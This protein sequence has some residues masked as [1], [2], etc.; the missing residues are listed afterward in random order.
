MQEVLGVLWVAIPAAVLI[1]AAVQDVSTREVSDTHW[2]VMGVACLLFFAASCIQEYGAVPVLCHLAVSVVLLSYMLSERLS[3]W[4]A[5][6]M[7][8][9]VVILSVVT[10]IMTD[11]MLSHASVVSLVV[12]FLFAGM[13]RVGLLRGGADAKCLMTVAVTYPVIPEVGPLPLIWDV[14]Y[15]E[16]LVFGTSV[17]VLVTSL[18]LSLASCAVLTV[19]NLREGRICSKMFTT[20]VIGVDEARHAFVWPVENVRG[21]RKLFCGTIYEGKDE[22]L[23]AL[24]SKGESLVTVT[25]M[26]PFVLPMAIAFITVSVLGSPLALLFNV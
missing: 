19:H 3:G 11:S 8:L 9:A 13:Y 26:I 14:P 24:S 16:S 22:V 18:F 21:G 17:S 10:A 2:M 4:F 1:S 5:L 15:P 20:Y 25:P 12:F 7:L 6:P 23:D